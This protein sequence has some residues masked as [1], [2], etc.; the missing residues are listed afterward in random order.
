MSRLQPDLNDLTTVHGLAGQYN[1]TFGARTNAAGGSEDSDSSP[2][3]PAV[4]I[5]PTPSRGDGPAYVA[6]AR[7]AATSMLKLDHISCQWRVTAAQPAGAVCCPAY[8][9]WPPGSPGPAPLPG[10]QH[11]YP[12][13]PACKILFL[14]GPPG[15]PAPPR[16]RAQR[17]RHPTGSGIDLPAARHAPG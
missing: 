8:G 15:V 6:A 16:M 9:H 14:A 3:Q 17:H 10:P 7:E 12:K 1:I 2:Y 11:A 5:S 13:F 4:L